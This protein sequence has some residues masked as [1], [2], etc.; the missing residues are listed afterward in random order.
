M[1]NIRIGEKVLIAGLYGEK[2]EIVNNKIGKIINIGAVD[3]DI[4]M[5]YFARIQVNDYVTDI[6]LDYIYKIP[7]K[8]QKQ[9]YNNH[10][11]TYFKDHQIIEYDIFVDDLIQ[12]NILGYDR[13]GGLK[14]YLT[15]GIN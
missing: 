12:H 14:F 8:K 4:S 3:S 15:S 5:I 11:H 2:H 7:N 9:L 13:Y 1:L 6:S 10:Y